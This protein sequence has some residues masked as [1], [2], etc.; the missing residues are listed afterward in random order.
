MVVVEAGGY[1]TD[2]NPSLGIPVFC[3]CSPKKTK[4]KKKKKKDVIDLWEV[5]KG[6]VITPHQGYRNQPFSIYLTTL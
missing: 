3:V 2:L 4:K 6:I 1:S 5:K